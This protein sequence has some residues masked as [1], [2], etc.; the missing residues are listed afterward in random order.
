MILPGHLLPRTSDKAQPSGVITGIDLKRGKA[1]QHVTGEQVVPGMMGS[2]GRKPVVEPRRP[3][4]T[5][6]GVQP[7]GQPRCLAERRSHISGN[8]RSPRLA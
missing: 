8:T 5:H 7:P 3:M 1:S 6:V 4:I 2:I